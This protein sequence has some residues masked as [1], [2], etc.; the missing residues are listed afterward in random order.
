VSFPSSEADCDQTTITTTA[1][2]QHLSEIE[3]TLSPV[4]SPRSGGYF[5]FNTFNTS[6]F[7]EPE[8]ETGGGSAI[9][10]RVRIAHSPSL[11]VGGSAPAADTAEQRKK[12][13]TASWGKMEM[14]ERLI[15]GADDKV[16]Q[17]QLQRE[18]VVRRESERVKSNHTGS[19]T[20]TGSTANVAGESAAQPTTTTASAAKEWRAA[21]NWVKPPPPPSPTTPPK[22]SNSANIANNTSPPS[23][24]TSRIGL[25]PARP[26]E[27]DYASIVRCCPLFSMLSSYQ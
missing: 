10:G 16:Q 17:Q 26:D 5:N 27:G 3:R 24:G 11:R 25:M 2:Q 18:R 15:K 6:G 4:G 13:K 9:V 19:G 22:L 12:A 7:D 14:F 21:T 23:G 8:T 20:S 1:Q